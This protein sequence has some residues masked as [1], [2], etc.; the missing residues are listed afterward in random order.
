MGGGK[1]EGRRNALDHV[2]KAAPSLL[3]VFLGSRPAT[4]F[5]RLLGTVLFVCPTACTLTRRRR[6]L[7]CRMHQSAACALGSASAIA[8][9][10]SASL[11]TQYDV[12]DADLDAAPAPRP[13]RLSCPPGVAYESGR[14]SSSSFVRRELS[15]LLLLN[16]TL[17][18]CW[19]WEKH[20]LPGESR[21]SPNHLRSFSNI[22]HFSQS[23]AQS[24]EKFRPSVAYFLLD[25]Q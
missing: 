16:A 22:S 14:P 7:P 10:A 4:S 8:L 15:R 5:S 11:R 21:A 2:T 23:I 18:T 17:T 3:P 24:L 19:S 25:A 20:W 13:I 9:H 1:A 6:R 12:P